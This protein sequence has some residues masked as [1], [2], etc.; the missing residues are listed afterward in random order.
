MAQFSWKDAPDLMDALAIAQNHPA[1]SMIDIMTFAGLCNSRDELEL[2]LARYEI[3]AQ[4]WDQDQ[5][6]RPRRQRRAA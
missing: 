5:E 4:N 6:M 1:N 3:H 2:H